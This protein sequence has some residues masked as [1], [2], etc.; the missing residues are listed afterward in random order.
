MKNKVIARTLK[1]Y[2]ARNLDYYELITNANNIIITLNIQEIR[3]SETSCIL[4]IINLC[5]FY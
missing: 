5:L 3:S 1:L 4:F 2:D